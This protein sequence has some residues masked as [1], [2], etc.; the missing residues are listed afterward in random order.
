[1]LERALKIKDLLSKK[2]IF[3][4]GPRGTGKTS[5]IK[6]Q[7]SNQALIVNLLSSDFYFRLSTRPA[8]LVQ[9]VESSKH[10]IIV[11]DEVQKIPALLDEVH[12]LIEEKNL[13]FL[14]TGSSARKL[15]RGGA[16]L[17]GGRAWDATLSP[18]TFQEI[19]SF[20]L[21]RY[22]RFGGLPAVYLS[23]F[24]DEELNA[25]V[26]TYLTEEIAAE[27]LVRDL[28]RFARFL[29]KSA[30]SNGM[31]LNFSEIASDLGVSPTTVREYYRILEDTL[32]G[33]MIEPLRKSGSR[34]EVSTAKFYFF[35]IGVSNTLRGVKNIEEGTPYFGN[36]FEQF[37]G[38]ELRAAISYLR[39]HLPL[40]FWRT[41]SQHEVDF[42]I[43]DM[44]AVEV[45]ATTSANMRMVKGLQSINV[46]FKIKHRCLISRDPVERIE[47]GITH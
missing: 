31:I 10:K 25:Y 11:I 16:N 39:L 12:N 46:S 45:K 15:R 20:D 29:Q 8:E 28:P 6:Q 14:L 9:I 47:D 44:L 43:G 24:P 17:L 38:Q 13:R 27:G 1:M 33:H 21:K 41:H 3:L 7:L 2:S 34:K 4:L 26:N 37:I 36:T 19:P 42:V 30:L 32:V 35:D 23:D 5:L 22:L 40:N 18:L